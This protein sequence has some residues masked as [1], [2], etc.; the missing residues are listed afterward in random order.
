MLV[1]Y[2]R[3]LAPEDGVVSVMTMTT[4]AQSSA[5]TMAALIIQSPYEAVTFTFGQLERAQRDVT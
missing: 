2:V 4:R 3:Y 1:L 5:M